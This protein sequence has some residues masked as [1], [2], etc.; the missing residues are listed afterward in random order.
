[1]SSDNNE[2][3][4]LRGCQVTRLLVA[5]RAPLRRR[6]TSEEVPHV[7]PE[8][9][10]LPTRLVQAREAVGLNITEAGT[11]RWERGFRLK[12]ASAVE[13]VRVAEKLKVSVGWLISGEGRGPREDG[14]DDPAPILAE[15]VDE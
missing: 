4:S 13:F 12:K 9:K 5:T 14:P 6:A 1:M 10:G 2:G 7:P 3:A 8:L 11:S 15:E